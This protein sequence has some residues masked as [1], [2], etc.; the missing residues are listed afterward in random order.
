MKILKNVLKNELNIRTEKNFPIE[1]IEFI[2]ITSLILQKETLKEITDKFV[3]FL[4]DKKIDY[5]VA[6][7]ARGFLFG[8]AVANKLNVGFI[9]VRKKGKLPPT[10]VE[11][12]FDYEK[13]YG[14][15]ILELPKLVNDEYKIVD[16]K[17]TKTLKERSAVEIEDD[18]ASLIELLISD[19]N[20]I[21]NDIEWVGIGSPGTV[22]T[23]TGVV[24]YA[25]NLNWL[26]V[27]LGEYISNKTGIKTYVGNDANVAA[28]G[29]YMAGSAKGSKSAV[30]ITLGTGVGAG[31]IIDGKIYTGFNYAGAELGHTV[32]EAD[33]LPC[34]CGRKG[35][36]EA[37]SSATGLIKMVKD[38]IEANPNSIMKQMA[39]EIGH[40]SGRIPFDANRKGDAS[41][42]R[43]VNK[44]IKYL[45]TGIT[46][47][48]NI[49]QP[50]ILCIGGG[51]AGE[52]EGLLLPL[53]E[54][55][56]KEV[57]SRNSDSN[58]NIVI[59]TLGNDAGII[60]AAL[61]GENS[62]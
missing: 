32:I 12:Q 46:N 39:D 41:A 21:K 53:R 34:T 51:V 16:V 27:P 15:D 38:E 31:I 26:N 24:E 47:A 40:I 44:Y 25:N 8:T 52:G 29:E 13:E 43:V 33:G 56:S 9:P 6:P 28:F 62:L 10:T 1:G 35:C 59:A 3:K 20:L 45:A 22:N 54:I 55:V 19:N 30:M 42:N 2:D 36:F 58:T 37:Y 60:G 11:M 18:I 49:F 23:D 17:K 61:L 7:E 48:I 14:K 5:I 50:E 4:K 57:Y